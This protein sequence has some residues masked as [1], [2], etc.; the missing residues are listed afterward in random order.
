MA[1]EY[2]VSAFFLLYVLQE[3]ARHLSKQSS[4]SSS[5]TAEAAPWTGL[6]SDQPAQVEGLRNVQAVS[7]GGVH[8]LAVVN[9]D[10]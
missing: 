1:H 8:A 2:C 7:L 6:G 3:H 4:S 10:D 9:D 5:Q